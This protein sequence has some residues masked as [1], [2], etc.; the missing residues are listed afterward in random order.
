MLAKKPQRKYALQAAASALIL[1]GT[2]TPWTLTELSAA[3]ANGM[4]NQSFNNGRKM[5]GAVGCF[6]CHRF[7]DEGG[8]TGP[9]LTGAGGR[10]S[11][12]DLLDQILNPS[13]EINQQ[14]V[15]TVITKLD[16]S[17]IT[18]TIVNLYQQRVTVNTDPA[19]PGQFVELHRET[20]RSIEPAKFSLM[21]PGLLN[22]LTKDEV[23]DLLAHVLSAGDPA[24]TMFTK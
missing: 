9:D 15:P 17:T 14:F 10:Y 19:N 21:P 24:N 6:S 18:G 13:K 12:H 1:R 2:M 11:A 16:G 8:M 23:L 7:G 20:I 4:K 22:M 3:A 5:F